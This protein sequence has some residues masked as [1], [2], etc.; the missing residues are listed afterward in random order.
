M[1]IQVFNNLV[2]F[3]DRLEQKRISYTLAHNRKEAILVLVAVPG[4]RW[5]IEFLC[6]GIVEVEKFVSTGEISDAESLSELFARYT[7]QEENAEST[8]GTDSMTLAAK[9]A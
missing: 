2:A 7:D 6:D 1:N 8:S 5:E 9:I 3:L 4:E